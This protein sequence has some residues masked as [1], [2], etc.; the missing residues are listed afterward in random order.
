MHRKFIALIITTAICVTGLSAAPARA[1]NQDA[2]RAI[3]G[4]TAL[5][6][7]GLAIHNARD[8]H[9]APVVSHAAPVVTHPPKPHTHS[10]NHTVRPRPLPQRVSRFD[11][12]RKC[13]RDQRL[14][15]GP[16]RLL[17]QQCLQDNY[18]FSAQLP[19]ACRVR[20]KSRTLTRTGYV[21][22]CLRNRGYRIVN[23]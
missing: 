7:L 8:K 19:G 18:R 11:L 2:A 15:G 21:P 9:S 4:L 17:G 14:H 1:D 12:P 10:Y 16:A 5:T 6:I 23:K 13:L 20:F 22:R 3:V